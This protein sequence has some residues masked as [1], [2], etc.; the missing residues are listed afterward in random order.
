MRKLRPLAIALLVAT[1]GCGD[2]G[3]P[4]IDAATGNDDGGQGTIDAPPGQ[5][6]ATIADARPRPDA[7]QATCTPVNGTNITTEIVAQGLD[8]PLFLTSPPG[9]ARLFILEQPGRIRIVEN[10]NLLT[11]P[12]LDIS[13]S[14]QNPRVDANGNE[15]GLL[16]LTF[17]PNY[18]KNGRFFVNYTATNPNNDTVIAEYTTS[19]DPNIA[20][21]TESRLLVIDQPYS[22]HNGGMLTFGPDG[23][24]YIGMGD[25]GLFDDPLEAGQDS[26]LWLGSMLRIDVDS[27]N[28]YGIPPTNPFSDSANGAKDPR[29]EIMHIGLR[30]PWRFSFDRQTGDLYI[31]DV[32]QDTREEISVYPADDP[33]GAN[34]GWDVLEGTYCHE[35]GPP[36][37]TIEAM[38]VPPA[39]EQP[40]DS[41]CAIIG[42]Y[43]Y[44]GTCMPDVDG[45][46]FYSDNCNPALR[47]FEWS[48]G[49]VS[50]HTTVPGS[51]GDDITSFGED[52][53][54]EI[55][56][57]NRSG[58]VRRLTTQ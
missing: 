45:W 17:H 41:F 32:G 29:P 47:K 43:V 28:P 24:L 9:D 39:I 34:F 13:A 31:G 49:N 21:T 55:Y 16:G 4:V 14:G 26:S 2:D 51:F 12:F 10:G 7:L 5:I 42:G 56:V 6:D 15:Q 50:N 19:N 25:G 8:D 36:C 1:F 46:Y 38:S 54:G 30:N 23:Y 40:T 44:R 33:P 48:N 18:G 22:N 3:T 57:V 11:T 37:A 20:N 53:T 52:A 35:P 58:T 27:G